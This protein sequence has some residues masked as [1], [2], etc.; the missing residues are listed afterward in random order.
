MDPA[1]DAE[2]LPILLDPASSDE[3]S[4]V[5][6]APAVREA[7]KLSWANATDNA[8]RLGMS[9]RDFLRTSMGAATVL[10]AL[11]ACSRDNNRGGRFDL[12]G[13]AGLDRDAAGSV[14]DRDLPVIDAQT[15]F[16]DYDLN[17]PEPP[18]FFGDHFPQAQ[19]G[20]ADA[21]ACFTVDQFVD[22]VFTRSET[23]LC[24]LSAIAA[25]DPHQGQ[26]PV[27]T[28]ARA[29]QRVA[30]VVGPGRML[31]HGLLAP[32]ERSLAAVHDDLE[33][34]VTTFEV[35]GW[36]AYTNNG[37]A[38]RLDDGDRNLPQVGLPSLQK[39]VDL[40]VPRICVHKGISG[41]DDA[42]APADVGPAA[43]QFPNV[44]FG[45][46]HSGWEPEVPEGP[47]TQATAGRGTNRLIASLQGAGIRP[48]QNVFAEIGSTWFN[49]MRKPDDAAHV[50]GKLLV[51]VGEDRLMWGTD[52]IWYGSPQDQIQAF[53]TFQISEAL[54]AAHGYPRMTPQLRA[55]VFGLNAVKPYNLNARSV[56][57][58]TERDA[59]AR[60]KAEYA[61]APN[62]SFATYG[63][64][65]RRQFL[66]LMR[67]SGGG[68]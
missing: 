53:R 37:R 24:V 13:D 19:C 35:S 59:V 27:E 4:P 22:V 47:F 16:L 5:P 3:Y 14:L 17:T 64:Q 36:K 42:L 57:Q 8:R 12:P 6:L 62:P 11:Q 39:I 54:Q 65:N 46:Y 7:R 67:A 68:P 33:A 48:N 21:R 32:S 25:P 60:E 63:P 15:H 2:Q 26:L 66:N 41:G 34:I 18:R 56:R 20:A 30:E 45:V 61:Q 40:G 55:K 28:M 43:K 10:L 50:I 52:S 44:K 1:S 58:Y 31:L 49:V 9:R 29:R 51:H 38:W 23:A